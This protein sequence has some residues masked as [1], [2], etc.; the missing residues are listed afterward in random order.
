[1]GALA[2]VKI[3]RSRPLFNREA[4]L[5][6][7]MALFFNCSSMISSIGQDVVL[8]LAIIIILVKL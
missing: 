3:L 2:P 4:G 5:A 1:M 7:T 8:V 6:A